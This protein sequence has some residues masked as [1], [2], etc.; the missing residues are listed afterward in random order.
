MR[1]LT[2][3]VW[4]EHYVTLRPYVLERWPQVDRLDLES[5]ND[6]FDA[7]VALV[8]RTTGMTAADVHRQIRTL[9]VE[10]LG[11]GPGEEEAPADDGK[12]S[13]AQLRLGAGF[14]EGDRER[15]EQ[16]LEKLNRRL[17]RFPAEGTE[18]W[19]TV[20]DR[21]ST[22]QQLTLECLAPRYAPLVA[23]SN[24]P[25]LRAAL[26]EVREELGRQ[27]NDAVTKRREGHR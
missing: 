26:L 23:T 12:A 1:P 2:H 13:L 17:K 10:E 6:D 18:L 19:L 25:D 21:D 14:T 3:Q 5:I 27:I 4:S 7:L 11:I 8:Q 22:S 20:K 15:V 16:R 24:E 9:E